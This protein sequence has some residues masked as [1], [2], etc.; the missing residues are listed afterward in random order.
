M[1]KRLIAL[2]IIVV[3]L[4]AFV[5]TCVS[6]STGIFSVDEERDYYEVIA[7]VKYGDLSKDIYKGQ[8]KAYINSYG[9]TYQQNYNMTIDEIAEYFYNTLTRSAMITLYAKYYI[10]E[11]AKA[12]V[13]EY[14]Y[15]DTS[16]DI[17]KLEAKDFITLKQLVYAI[18]QVNDEV[19]SSYDSLV[20]NLETN[21]EEEE[22]EEDEDALDPR[23]VRTYDEES[24][25]SYDKD[26]TCKSIAA[27]YG[28]DYI[29]LTYDEITSEF[30]TGTLKVASV[31]EFIDS[32][33]VFD[34]INAKIKAE[35]ETSKKKNMK[36][37]LKTL[38][39]NISKSYSEYN[40][41][42]E[43]KIEAC[44]L[45]V[46][47]EGL[48]EA[49][50]GQ[51]TTDEAINAKYEKLIID[52]L[53]KLD[54]DT[55]ATSLSGSTFMPV[56][57]A[58]DY[59]GVKSILLKF[60]DA[61]SNVLTLLKTQ[62][63]ADSE[64]VNQLRDAMAIGS[65][66]GTSLGGDALSGTILK[67]YLDVEELNGIRVNIS[68]AFYNADEDKKA[69]AYTDKN[70][71]YQVVLY[72]MA[73]S[74]ASISEEITTM[75]TNSA[76]YNAIEDVNEK[77]TRL[78]IVQ[79]AAKVEAFTQWMYLVNDDSGMFSSE[80]YAVTPDNKSTSYVAE[81][82]VLARKLAAQDIGDY[83]SS[84]Y[85]TGS[86]KA[87]VVTSEEG[88]SA[89]YKVDG[90]SATL[91]VE[92][93]TSHTDEEEIKARVYTLKTEEGNAISFIINDYGIHIVLVAEQ[94]GKDTFIAD[95]T[96]ALVDGDK[97]GFKF[98]QNAL[99]S[100]GT[101]IKYDYTYTRVQATDTF[102]ANAEY[103]VWN[104]DEYQ[105]VTLTAETFTP[106]TKTYFT[107]VW[108]L[109]KVECD[110]ETLYENLKQAVIDE[111]FSTKYSESQL[112]L[113]LNISTKDAKI[114]KVDKVYD[115]LLKEFES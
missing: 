32:I 6:C 22:E 113:Y 97:S 85:T 72:N 111:L 71:N 102:D 54:A 9:A 93:E 46:L 13:A 64:Y 52:N 58:Q 15:V 41:F 31:D 69:D 14:S 37:A 112:E 23:T 57:A 87:L 63:K 55:Y 62:Y 10:Y 24:R 114:N 7:T 21:D 67:D 79:Y 50:K 45:N 18:D 33:D 94:Y 12:S 3:M 83:T 49:A 98:K 115:E 43:D 70:V 25:S 28:A 27:V 86:D 107:R 47:K 99:Y 26:L 91:Y 68:N 59:S 78:A 4:A 17:D 2:V 77:A 95:T 80:S 96:E 73:N 48:E 92:N 8:L 40:K 16:K 82:T 19:L 44:I 53:S 89:Q 36:S 100:R 88:I 104:V 56:N 110:Y 106:A 90:K 38:K 108:E 81:Y 35:T 29:N 34:V 42:L 11:Q 66:F 75:Y 5:F 101:T 60:S 51:V 109:Q 30:I 1:K 39:D 61:Q 76:E 74:I 103:F 20:A 65:T 105:K 84:T